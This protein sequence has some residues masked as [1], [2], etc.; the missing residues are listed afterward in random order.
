MSRGISLVYLAKYAPNPFTSDLIMH[1]YQVYEA[2]VVSEVL[3]LCEHHKIDAVVIAADVEDLDVI[4]A[5]LRH[6]TL[7]LKPN[8]TPKDMIWEL[9]NLFGKRSAKIH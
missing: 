8:A 5:Q 6:I 9:E 7:R 2:L 4:E 1:G 3:Y